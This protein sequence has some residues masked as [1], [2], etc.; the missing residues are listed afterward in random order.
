MEG[1]I[2]WADNCTF[3]SQ[4]ITYIPKT[5]KD[6]CGSIC[7][8]N[9]QCALFTWDMA[10]N[11]SCW[12]KNWAGYSS[13][14]EDGLRCG[15]IPDRVIDVNVLKATVTNLTATVSKQQSQLNGIN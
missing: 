5:N 1:E 7:L 3:R 13:I 12:L 6:D 10:S 15:F 14:E 8:A 2:Q 4:D 9:P 11:G